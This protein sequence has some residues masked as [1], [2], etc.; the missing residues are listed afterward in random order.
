MNIK[1]MLENYLDQKSK[2]L[3]GQADI[4]ELEKMLQY[5]DVIRAETIQDAIEGEC[6]PAPTL[7]HIPRSETNKFH[8]STENAAL[9]YK[10]KTWYT[11]GNQIY[12][13]ELLDRNER[14]RIQLDILRIKQEI[15]PYEAHVKR[16][17]ALLESLN[18]KENFV[19]T[20]RYIRGYNQPEVVQRFAG[21]FG[22]G[23]K[24]TIDN[25][26][27]DAFAK[28]SRVKKKPA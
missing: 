1:Q 20:L 23:S 4:E 8:S 22:Y 3:S 10:S 6:M 17:D 12:Y 15:L 24:T 18:D 11:S 25:M 7:S 19:I 13:L 27:K 21:Q 28:M 9:N 2:L 5:D 14:K 16:V 26:E